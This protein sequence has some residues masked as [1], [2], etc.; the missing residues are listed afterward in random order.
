VF[1]KGAEQ[2][3]TILA[4]RLDTSGRHRQPVLQCVGYRAEIGVVLPNRA[5]DN[6]RPGVLE[7]EFLAG[8]VYMGRHSASIDAV[9]GRDLN[10]RFALLGECEPLL[11]HFFR[12]Y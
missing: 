4:R 12:D 6:R 1:S 3:L 2:T 11:S 5:P 7:A 8:K 10:K 9:L